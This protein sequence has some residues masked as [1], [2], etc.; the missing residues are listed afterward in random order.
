MDANEN[1][2]QKSKHGDQTPNRYEHEIQGNGTMGVS[3]IGGQKKNVRDKLLKRLVSRHT[4]A[5]RD[6]DRRRGHTE[7]ARHIIKAVNFTPWRNG[8]RS[9][10]VFLRRLAGCFILDRPCRAIIFRIAGLGNPIS[11]FLDLKFE[12]YL[13]TLFRETVLLKHSE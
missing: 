13:V 2:E 8:P 11:G 3:L 5:H 6:C 12:A 4:A 9:E 7:N 10:A 1:G